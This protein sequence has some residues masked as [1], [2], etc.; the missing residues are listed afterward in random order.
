MTAPWGL[1]PACMD[2]AQA[3]YDLKKEA[4]AAA[5]RFT[6]YQSPTAV[7]YLREII[8]PEGLAAGH[9]FVVADSAFGLLGHYHARAT[10]NTYFLNYIAVSATERQL[11][12]GRALYAHFEG[13]ARRACL[14]N[15]ALDVTNENANA[16][17]WYLRL[18]YRETSRTQY[19]SLS[20][21]SLRNRQGDTASRAVVVDAQALALALADESLR[22]FSKVDCLVDNKRV[23]IGLIAGHVCKLLSSEVF[24]PATIMAV[25]RYF[26]PQ[27]D[28]LIATNAGYIPAEWSVDGRETVLRLEKELEPDGAGSGWVLR[29]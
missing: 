9:R 10:G 21:A 4:F 2:D 18:G 22:G 5:L 28:Q 20:T 12:L 6:I 24:C 11:G 7:S 29:S 19:V 23:V 13:Q 16:R 15:V 1:R 27:R 26:G 14:A 3:V 17:D 8:G 25:A